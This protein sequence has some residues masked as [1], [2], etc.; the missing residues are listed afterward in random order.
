MDMFFISVPIFEGV[1]NILIEFVI[2]SYIEEQCFIR[3]SY[4][5]K[6]TLFF[7]LNKF[8]ISGRVM[9]SLKSQLV[10][11]DVRVGRSVISNSLQIH[12]P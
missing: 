1:C 2:L 6:L 4:S 11:F 10:T 8:Y 12:G 9:A 5:F 3:I 7:P